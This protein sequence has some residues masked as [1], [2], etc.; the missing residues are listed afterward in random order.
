VTKVY[1]L[2]V[3]EVAVAA[4]VIVAAIALLFYG[5]VKIRQAA[6]ATGRVTQA[7]RANAAR[8]EREGRSATKFGWRTLIA[9]VLF[10]AFVLFPYNMDY[11][12]Y[13]HVAGTVVDGAWQH[14]GEPIGADLQL[15]DVSRG[16]RRRQRQAAA[17]AAGAHPLST[18]LGWN[19]ALHPGAPTGDDRTAP[20]P[21]C[22][23]CWF[24]RTFS[25]RSGTWPKCHQ[26]STVTYA[27]GSAVEGLAR[28]THGP[29]TDVKAWWPAC[30][31]YSSG[32]TRVSDDAAR[33]TP[34]QEGPLA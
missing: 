32:D 6:G 2:F 26:P 14:L 30:I 33:W 29:G 11:H 15:L 7:G 23:S 22:G 8:A 27:D 17:I 4:I 16:V 21:R 25:H 5:R 1:P 18:A 34:Q 20:G 13:R 19:I 9:T 31:D 28:V 3:F 10:A 12:Q 24:R